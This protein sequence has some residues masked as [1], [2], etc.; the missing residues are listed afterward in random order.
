M[1]KRYHIIKNNII[2]NS[3]VWDGVSPFDLDKDC[4]VVQSDMAGLGDKIENNKF[5]RKS[6]IKI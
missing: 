5:F 2:I 4:T 3:I 6:R 1:L